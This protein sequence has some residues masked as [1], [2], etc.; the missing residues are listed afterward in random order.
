MK[1]GVKERGRE[2]ERK[3]GR[4]GR[5]RKERSEG[6]RKG[7]REGRRRRRRERERDS[8][9]IHIDQRDRPLVCRHQKELKHYSCVA[10]YDAT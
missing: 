4:E 1:G 6:T 8:K 7:G 9:V 3:G 10:Y 5:S 2:G